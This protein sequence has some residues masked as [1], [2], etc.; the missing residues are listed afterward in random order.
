MA[1]VEAWKDGSIFITENE[2]RSEGPKPR[3]GLKA[4]ARWCYKGDQGAVFPPKHE[5]RCDPHLL[6]TLQ[7]LPP[8][9]T[10]NSKPLTMFWLQS[11][12]HLTPCQPFSLDTEPRL[13][14]FQN[15]KH[16]T[17]SPIGAETTC[18]LFPAV[19]QC[20]GSW[21]HARHRDELE[22]Y[23]K[24]TNEWSFDPTLGIMPRT[25]HWRFKR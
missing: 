4:W 14:S 10:M 6:R 13:N 3:E 15:G 19:S 23:C 7:W 22:K 25:T 12:L 2:R 24:C 16:C 18:V 11:P 8:A 1:S 20:P 5:S 17:A 21:H 9:L